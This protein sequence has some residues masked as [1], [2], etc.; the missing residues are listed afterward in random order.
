MQIYIRVSYIHK[1]TIDM[2]ISYLNTDEGVGAQ[3]QRI[4]GLLGISRVHNFRY[5]H[6]PITV[7][8]NYD[9]DAEWDQ[10]W[11]DFFN[12]K[13]L[14]YTGV[15]QEIS[16]IVEK[17]G[18]DYNDIT[19][20]KNNIIYLY[21]LPFSIVDNHPNLYYKSVQDDIIKVYDESTAKKELF[22]FDKNKI[23]VA[24]HIRVFNDC[25]VHNFQDF[26]NLTGRHCIKSAEYLSLINTLK[27][28]HQNV[29]FHIFSQPA[30]DT[31]YSEL[32]NL[33]NVHIHLDTNAF[34]TFHHLCKADILVC[35]V[36]SFSYLAAVYNKNHVIYKPF[37]HPPLDNWENIDNYT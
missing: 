29:E 31:K 16:H 13:T 9:N 6:K 24:I 22:L 8:H 36:S 25:D 27:S 17:G 35:A 18:M 26:E 14:T 37:W 23:N 12:I 1:Y 11:D 5:V 19:T 21:C 34:D 15:I 32:K 10:K 30:F 4:V 2:F 3:Y 33:E 28:K 7:G 20:M